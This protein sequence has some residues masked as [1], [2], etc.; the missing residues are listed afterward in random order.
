M[1][2]DLKN[3]ERFHRGLS[4][5][6]QVNRV[7]FR[8]LV[9]GCLNPTLRERHL[10]YSYQRAAI[11][12]EQLVTITNSQQFQAMT[13]IAR[14]TLEVAIE[15]GMIN[16]EPNASERIEAYNN[17]EKLKAATKI[18]TYADEHPD[19]KIHSATYRKFVIEKGAA[20]R[21]E[22]DRLWPGVK[23][24]KMQ[25]WTLM[26]ISD[27]AKE[28]GVIFHQLYQANY[29]EL[30]WFIHGGTTGVMNMT[31]EAAAQLAGMCYKLTA[32]CFAEI[33]EIV[34]KEFRLDFADDIIRKRIL[35]ARW[36][37]FTDSPEEKAGLLREMGVEMKQ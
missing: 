9:E 29:S 22:H 12:T 10:T 6:L 15:M 25:H 30:S 4:N 19:A 11:N 5:L 33:L 18:V 32:D 13:M 37:P 14:S 24:S 35:H 2:P 20:I 34:I 27:R 26:S 16:R 1:E 28:L 21:A 3:V 31:G 17:I 23:M 7:S 36:E 8:P